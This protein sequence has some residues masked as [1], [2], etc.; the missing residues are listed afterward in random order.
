VKA[1]TVDQ[2]GAY[3]GTTPLNTGATLAIPAAVAISP[4]KTFPYAAYQ[5]TG[6]DTFGTIATNLGV[7]PAVLGPLNATMPNLFNVGVKIAYP[8]STVTTV[9]GDT[10]TTLAQR[11]GINVSVAT[12]AADPSVTGQAGLVAEDALF[13]LNLPVV[14]S[15]TL[16]Q[17][18]TDYDVALSDLALVNSALVG[19]VSAGAPFSAGG[20]QVTSVANDTLQSLVYRFATEQQ[21]TTTVAELAQVN[22]GLSGALVSTAQFVLP[23]TATTLSVT[24]PTPFVPAPIFP[25]TVSLGMSRSDTLIDDEFRGVANVLTNETLLSPQPVAGSDGS[26]SLLGFAEAFESAFASYR[27][28]V[29][30]GP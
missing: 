17:L 21:V 1:V 27:L 19:F 23:P 18:A 22:Q 4:T 5:A 8:G 14:G 9:T 24:F 26:L 3:N 2:L 10:F 12:F 7:Q 13:I 30:T 29:A 25:L 11:A 6:Q 16:G 20:K 28:K 15:R